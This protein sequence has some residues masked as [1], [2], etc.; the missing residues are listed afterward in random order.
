[1]LPTDPKDH[2]EIW[3]QIRD[4][5][6][7][8]SNYGKVRRDIGTRCTWS[9]RILKSAPDSDGYPKVVLSI[10]N[11]RICAAVHVLV[12]EAFNGLPQIGQN[13]VR[14][15]DGN[16]LNICPENLKWGSAKENADDRAIHGN[17]K[18]GEFSAKAKLTDAKVLSLRQEYN[19]LKVEAISS[20]KKYVPRGWLFDLSKELG[21]HKQSVLKILTG[22]GYL[23]A[24]SN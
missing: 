10:N 1:M 9:G 4:Y 17:T 6:Y 24:S 7:S 3:K 22:Q 19:R 20:G 14:H 16:K 23:N 13:Q 12:C 5:P 2:I 15:L 11:K 18:R 21:L 8:V